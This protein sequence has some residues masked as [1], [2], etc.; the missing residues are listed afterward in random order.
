MIDVFNKLHCLK[1]NKLLIIN[2]FLI[3]VA[4]NFSLLPSVAQRKTSFQNLLTELL[5]LHSTCALASV[6]F[7]FILNWT[8]AF[9]NAKVKIRTK[10]KANVAYSTFALASGAK[11][12]LIWIKVRTNCGL[13]NSK[14]GKRGEHRY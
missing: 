12:I 8:F 4:L 14:E 10:W 9:T 1:N 7:V 2:S 5:P 3:S 6:A 13:L 11:F